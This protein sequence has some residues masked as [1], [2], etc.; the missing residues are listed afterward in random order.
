MLSLV[1]VM[2]KKRTEPRIANASQMLRHPLCLGLCPDPICGS[3]SQL[4]QTGAF[5]TDEY[6]PCSLQLLYCYIDTSRKLRAFLEEDRDTFS[7]QDLLL[8]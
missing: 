7:S 5:D 2:M 3:V 4:I 1:K 8:H 6:P